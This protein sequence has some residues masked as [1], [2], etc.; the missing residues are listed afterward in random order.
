MSADRTGKGTPAGDLAPFR[1]LRDFVEAFF[2]QHGGEVTRRGELSKVVV[3]A[4]LEE[5]FGRAELKLVFS[6]EGARDDAESVAPGSFILESILK[7]MKGRGERLRLRLPVRHPLRKGLLRRAIQALDAEAHEPA[8]ERRRK[9]QWVFHM[10]LVY[11]SDERIDDLINV[12]VDEADVARE[13]DP[14]AWLDPGAKVLLRRHASPGELEARFQVAARLAARVARDRAAEMADAIHDRLRHTVIRLKSYYSD[15]LAE[16]PRGDPARWRDAT[17]QVDDE[18]EMKLAEEVENHRQRVVI[19]LVSYAEIEVPWIQATME[20]TRDGVRG[21][22]GVALDQTTGL[23]TPDPCAACAVPTSVVSLCSGGHVVCTSCARVCTVCGRETCL[24]CGAK[25]CAVC[26]QDACADCQRTCDDCRGGTCKSHALE[27][28]RCGRTSCTSCG[29]RCRRCDTALCGRCHTHCAT[30][31]GAVCRSCALDCARCRKPV[32]QSESTACA[33]CGRTHCRSCVLRCDFCDSVVCRDHGSR[34]ATC[35]RQGCDEHASSCSSCGSPRCIEHVHECA[36][37]GRDICD[38][39]SGKCTTCAR[40][41]CARDGT[42]CSICDTVLCRAHSPV[43]ATCGATACE[44]HS[45][46]CAPCGS[47]LCQGH[48]LLCASCGEHY[49]N[50]CMPGPSLCALCSRLAKAPI[51]PRTTA[52]TMIPAGLPADLRSVLRWRCVSIRDRRLLLCAGEPR[53]LLVLDG[54]GNLV[55]RVD[56]GRGR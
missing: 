25:A 45:H 4:D 19:R 14:W 40:A 52:E 51:V 38:G 36:V 44:R 48:A 42:R 35:S 20:L 13:V 56:A 24:L 18:Y 47:T 23:L 50:R 7:Q 54:A 3:G 28:G 30:C 27:C 55:R 31:A 8:I 43:C 5:V 34:C 2:L 41:V 22:H 33:R 49:C 1:G 12:A 21:E 10:R 29:A 46:T 26:T 17:E 11:L 6:A 9:R 15:R 32:C 16:V 37:C 53:E 39:C